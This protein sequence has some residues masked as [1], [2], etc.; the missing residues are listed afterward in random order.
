MDTEERKFREVLR[1]IFGDFS[2]LLYNVEGYAYKTNLW[3]R[4][5]ISGDTHYI[6]VLAYS[7]ENCGYTIIYKYAF[8]NNTA[9]AVLDETIKYGDEK[10]FQDLPY[11]TV[12]EIYINSIRETWKAKEAVLKIHEDEY[13]HLLK[14]AEVEMFSIMSDRI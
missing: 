10:H 4:E 8:E 7:Y 2:E 11:E 13:E 9:Q 3:V 5:N 12:G 14:G 1:T 6:Y